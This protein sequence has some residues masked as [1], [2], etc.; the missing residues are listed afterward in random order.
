MKIS[1]TR[2][3]ARR[4]LTGFAK[5]TGGVALFGAVACPLAAS[6]ASFSGDNWTVDLSGSVAVSGDAFTLQPGGPGN[7]SNAQAMADLQTTKTLKNGSASLQDAYAQL[8]S[9]VATQGSM[10]QSALSAATALAQQAS[11]A[12][13]SASGVNLDHEA[14]NLIQFQQA[15][16]AA[17]KAVQIGT[18]LFSSLLQALG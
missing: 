18:S 17:A 15:Y 16:Q 11:S 3:V 12:Q 13:Q 4:R 8:A 9:S 6:A 14:T 5:L 2:I 1:T 7:G 10:S